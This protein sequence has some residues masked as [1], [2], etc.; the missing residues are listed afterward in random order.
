MAI[1]RENPDLF[2]PPD[3]ESEARL[4]AE[5]VEVTFVDPIGISEAN[6]LKIGSPGQ[7]TGNLQRA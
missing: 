1:V 7:N 6:D 5:L 2:V 4:M 3:L